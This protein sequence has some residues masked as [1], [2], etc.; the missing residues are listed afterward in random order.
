MPTISCFLTLRG[1]FIFMNIRKYPIRSHRLKNMGKLKYGPG[2][3][4]DV[5]SY[6]TND[7]RDLKRL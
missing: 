2:G 3:L 4:P 1:T 5:K 7:G 6:T